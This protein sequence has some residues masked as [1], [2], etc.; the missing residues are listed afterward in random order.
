MQR[1]SHAPQTPKRNL[2]IVWR[3]SFLIKQI[4]ENT[5]ELYV[6]VSLLL[7][8]NVI[9]QL[10]GTTDCEQRSFAFIPLAFPFVKAELKTIIWILNTNPSVCMHAEEWQRKNNSYSIS[11]NMRLSAS[12][13]K[14]QQSVALRQRILYAVYH[15]D[16]LFNKAIIIETKLILNFNF[17]CP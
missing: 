2:D 5:G 15:K 9:M 6:M 16:Y 7:T 4:T 14:I 17:S 3:C 13:M 1:L 11:W 8:K 10:N 12:F